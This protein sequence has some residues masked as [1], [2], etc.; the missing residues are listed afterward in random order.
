MSGYKTIKVN[1]VDSKHM[2]TVIVH[3]HILT[4]MWFTVK[5]NRVYIEIYNIA[6]G[7]LQNFPTNL[8]IIIG[9][10]PDYSYLDN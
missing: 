3:V 8:H 2:A 6:S 4:P 1:I 9:T 10:K 7:P 5:I